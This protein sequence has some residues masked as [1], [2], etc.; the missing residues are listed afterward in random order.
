MNLVKVDPISPLEF[1]DGPM[2]A[3]E[4]LRRD[5]ELLRAGAFAVR[6]AE[7]TDRTISVGA[8]QRNSSA[9]EQSAREQGLTLHRRT[10]GGLGLLLLPGDIVWSIVLPPNAAGRAPTRSYGRFGAGV[11]RFLRNFGVDAAW[12]DAWDLSSSYCLLGPRGQVLAGND[13][14]IG[15]AAQHLTRTGLLHHG[16]L[17]AQR[18]EKLL[19]QLF[20]ISKS[21]VASHL[22]SLEELRIPYQD[23]RIRERLIREIASGWVPLSSD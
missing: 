12:V 21:L 15:G 8:G 13:R 11:V 20:G 23:G 9:L 7:L 22:T 19:H 3:E 2:T 4:N 10:S 1:R 16:V 14:A 17:I 6:V 5:E 18:R